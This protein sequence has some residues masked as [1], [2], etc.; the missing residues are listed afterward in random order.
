MESGTL[1]RY[2]P[3]IIK[4]RMILLEQ[5]ANLPLWSITNKRNRVLLTKMNGTEFRFPFGNQIKP[6][7]IS[8]FY[9]KNNQPANK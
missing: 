6:E 3:Q 4:Q 5:L 1:F 8:F 7:H 9:L 2:T